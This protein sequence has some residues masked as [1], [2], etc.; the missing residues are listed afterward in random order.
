MKTLTKNALMDR[1]CDQTADT[2]ILCFVCDRSV[3]VGVGV[4][5]R[6][7]TVPYSTGTVVVLLCFILS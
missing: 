2:I 1:R 4:S 3:G 6:G 5:G 7:Y